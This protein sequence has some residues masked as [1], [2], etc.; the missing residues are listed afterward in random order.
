VSDHGPDKLMKIA[1]KPQP[2]KD[3]SKEPG[4]GE[5][6]GYTKGYLKLPPYPHGDY[7]KRAIY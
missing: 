3:Y 5:G 2:H 4:S 1:K 7:T 6:G